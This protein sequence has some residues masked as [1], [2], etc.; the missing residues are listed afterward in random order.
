MTPITFVPYKDPFH[1]SVF[2]SWLIIISTLYIL[3]IV[4]EIYDKGGEI[5]H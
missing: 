4:L 2:K 3:Y 1:D 5:V